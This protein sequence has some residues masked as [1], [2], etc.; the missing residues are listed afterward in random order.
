MQL[1]V[2]FH[3]TTDPLISSPII[4]VK[5]RFN[6]SILNA[7]SIRAHNSKFLSRVFVL[8]LLRFPFWNSNREI[9]RC[10][11][12]ESTDRLSTSSTCMYW[13]LLHCPAS[14]LRTNLSP[15]G[16][17]SACRATFA[18]LAWKYTRMTRFPE[19]RP[20]FCLPSRRKCATPDWRNRDHR[21]LS[22]NFR[23]HV[24]SR[25][26]RVCRFMRASV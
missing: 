9:L 23:R 16:F 8:F 12:T 11:D 20:M 10:R 26:R 22:S 24:F 5:G 17:C 7:G 21:E 15:S 14:C 13:L 18:T 3:V 19:T 2:I 4:L 25:R 6:R 1:F